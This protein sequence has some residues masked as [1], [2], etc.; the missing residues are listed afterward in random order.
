MKPE[1]FELPEVNHGG[2]QTPFVP[3]VHPKRNSGKEPFQMRNA[4]CADP[5][6]FHFGVTSKSVPFAGAPRP[7]AFCRSSGRESAP[8]KNHPA[9]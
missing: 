3:I 1:V 8:S 7:P 4:E 9:K 6:P 5:P 2:I